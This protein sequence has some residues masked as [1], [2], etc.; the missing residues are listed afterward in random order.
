MKAELSA[1]QLLIKD[2]KQQMKNG[3]LTIQELAH[4]YDGLFVAKKPTFEIIYKDGTRSW[5]IIK[6]KKPVAFIVKGYAV[7][8]ARS[9]Q[10]LNWY[11]AQNY[12]ENQSFLGQ[13]CSCGSRE[14]WFDVL[15]PNIWEFNLQLVRFRLPEINPFDILWTDTEVAQGQAAAIAYFLGNRFIEASGKL[16]AYY[17]RPVAKLA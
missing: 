7:A 15:L 5:N 1:K 4:A 14:F 13:S 9:E 3:G 17:A 12:C 10:Y 8:V 6:G 2:I 11:E 16:N